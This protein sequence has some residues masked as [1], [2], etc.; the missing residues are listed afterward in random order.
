MYD[1]YLDTPARTSAS[2]LTAEL[3]QVRINY[4]YCYLKIGVK[5]EFWTGGVIQYTVRDNLVLPEHF[6]NFLLINYLFSL[7]AA[8]S[9]NFWCF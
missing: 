1:E 4:T 7:Y 9:L 8:M 6:S 5:S 3:G 2:N